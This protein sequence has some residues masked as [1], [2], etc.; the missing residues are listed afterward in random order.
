MD[1]F[2]APPQYYSP[3]WLGRGG[4]GAHLQTVYPFVFDRPDTALYA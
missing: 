4:F 1:N 3:W 2:P